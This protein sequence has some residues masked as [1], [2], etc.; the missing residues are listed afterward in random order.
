MTDKNNQLTNDMLVAD[1]MLRLTAI[2]KLLLDKVVFTQAE[3]LKATNDIAETVS[4][5]MIAKAKAAQ[6]LE[7]F[8]VD[9]EQSNKKIESN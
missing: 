3:L 9:L 2:E 5:A 8:I 7:G 4:Q 6:N 1:I